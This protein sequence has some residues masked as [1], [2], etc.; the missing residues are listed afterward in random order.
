MVGG[1]MDKG[2][3][4]ERRIRWSNAVVFVMFGLAIF[5]KASDFG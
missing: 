3:K 5:N 1:E 4:G 2:E